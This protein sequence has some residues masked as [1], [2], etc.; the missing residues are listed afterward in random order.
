MRADAAADTTPPSLST[1]CAGAASC[2]KP[3]VEIACADESA[4]YT[5]AVYVGMTSSESTDIV[6]YCNDATDGC[7]AATTY[8][9]MTGD[10]GATMT[11]NYVN[12]WWTNPQLTLACG[13]TYKFYVHASDSLGNKTTTPSEV[14]FTIAAGDDAAAPVITDITETS[15]AKA[16][17]QLIKVQTDSSAT[18]YYCLTGASCDND[19][20]ISAMT[21]MNISSGDT[22]HRESQVV[23]AE[24][25]AATYKVKCADSQD[26]VSAA[27]T[28]SI[29]TKAALD[30]PLTGGL[31]TG[32]L[33]TGSLTLT[34]IP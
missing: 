24:G 15:Q 13:A 26:N 32:T 19:T 1:P 27:T 2:V 23:Q 21:Q 11:G 33:G 6:R 28:V 16:Q 29:T 18:C 12:Y 9:E 8:D 31:L 4:P 20:L 25:T 17:Y 5:Q 10:V 22:N 30:A 14:N 7:S 3:P 34:I